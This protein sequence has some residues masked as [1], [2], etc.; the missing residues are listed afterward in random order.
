MAKNLHLSAAKNLLKIRAPFATP[1]YP[2]LPCLFVVRDARYDPL[3]EIPISYK[4]GYEE[5]LSLWR[6]RQLG[7]AFRF[8]PSL[9]NNSSRQSAGQDGGSTGGES[10]RTGSGVKWPHATKWG[11][12]R[13]VSAVR[14]ATLWVHRVS[15]AF[16]VAP[17]HALVG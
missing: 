5:K 10:H 14:F 9:L 3:D 12:Q 11:A 17:R 6:L 7:V 2:T 1:R 16:A 13:I 4:D 8:P 15:E